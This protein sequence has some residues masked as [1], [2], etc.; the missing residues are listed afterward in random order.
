ML[1]LMR[2]TK[3]S[4][5]LNDVSVRQV[6][7]YDA[8]VKW[9]HMYLLGIKKKNLKRMYEWFDERSYTRF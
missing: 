2:W 4:E 6:K 3:P 9:V 8:V 7:V 5:E 1:L